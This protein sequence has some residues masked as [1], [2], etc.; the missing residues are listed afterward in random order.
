MDPFR[1]VVLGDSIPW[2]QGLLPVHKYPTILAQKLAATHA[3]STDVKAHSGAT[4]GMGATAGASAPDGEVPDAYPT[5]LTQCTT[6]TQAPDTVDLVLLNGGIND[7]GVATIVNPLTTHDHLTSQT[8]RYCYNDMRRLLRAAATTF[9]KPTAR[10]VVTGYYPILSAASDPI[11]VRHLLLCHGLQVPTI[12]AE[13]LLLER[14]VDLCATFWHTSDT[15]LARAVADANAAEG[16]GR[17]RFV[18]TQFQPQ[19]AAYGPAA[20]LFSLQQDFALSPT[21]EV[22]PQRHAMCELFHPH[23]LEIFPR[24]QCFRASVGHPNI[25]GA[26]HYADVISRALQL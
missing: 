10:I 22:I 12:V 18:P 5:I 2:G 19:N 3:V 26:Q 14:L 23:P 16:Q 9:T 20:W 8:I 21:D 11:G 1:I 7:V 25:A 4:I 6:Y 17:I 15:S 24:E 13:S